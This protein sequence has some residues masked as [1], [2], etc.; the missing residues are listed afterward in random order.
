MAGQHQL[1]DSS[2]RDAE[3]AETVAYTALRRLQNRYADIVTRRAWPELAEIMT[4]DCEVVVDTM[5]RQLTVRG[6]AE[7]G[8]F[9]A[10]QLAQFSF[11]EFVVLNTVM[12]IDV[13]AGSAGARMY[14]HELRQGVADGRRT[15]AYGVY[16]DRLE[17]DRSGRWWFANRRYRSYSRTAP[18]EAE[19][20]QEVFDVPQIPLDEL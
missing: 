9:I 7:A 12:N 6:P 4:P 10:A 8:E 1:T 17:R 18:P 2:D 20:D 15:D 11:F 16:H 19:F 3:I 13:A 5:D 14:M